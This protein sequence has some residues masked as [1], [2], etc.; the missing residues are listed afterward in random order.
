MSPPRPIRFV[1]LFAP[2]LMFALVLALP[3]SSARLSLLVNGLPFARVVPKEKLDI[4]QYVQTDNSAY[5][6]VVF[7]GGKAVGL[8]VQPHFSCAYFG[9]FHG[10]ANSVVGEPPPFGFTMAILIAWSWRWFLLPMQAVLLLL[11][12][13]QRERRTRKLAHPGSRA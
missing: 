2:L 7:S 10:Q 4:F 8:I 6:A 3:R 13:R 12:L 9:P 5:E 11:W 1:L